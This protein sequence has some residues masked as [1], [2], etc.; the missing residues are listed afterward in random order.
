MNTPRKMIIY[1]NA[2][3]SL[4]LRKAT[5]EEVACMRDPSEGRKETKKK[6]TVS[7]K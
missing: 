1:N 6:K 3:Y 2:A 7:W 4:C 5:V